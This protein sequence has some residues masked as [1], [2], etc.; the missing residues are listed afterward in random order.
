MP[1]G[2]AYNLRSSDI[3]IGRNSDND[4]VLESPY[5]SKYH[6]VLQRNKLALTLKDCGSTN[7]T[8]VNEARVVQ[9]VALNYGDNITICETL[10]IVALQTPDGKVEY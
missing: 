6:A 4:I 7:G 8:K 1:S 10:F 9:P 3:R 5:A 2:D